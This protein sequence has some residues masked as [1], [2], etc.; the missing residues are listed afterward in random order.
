MLLTFRLVRLNRLLEILETRDQVIKAFARK[1]KEEGEG[2]E[3][4]EKE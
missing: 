4:E 2:E 3:T 1:E